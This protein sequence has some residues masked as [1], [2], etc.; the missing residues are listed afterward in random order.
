M[1]K[2]FIADS[3]TCLGQ[4]NTMI[5]NEFA[6]L[7]YIFWKISLGKE[8]EHLSF[9][10]TI[11]IGLFLFAWLFLKEVIFLPEAWECFAGVVFFSSH[12]IPD[13]FQLVF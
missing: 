1:E 4:A 2:G 8:G 10:K 3:V 6:V 9:F 12:E 5:H 7:V 11:C 13:S